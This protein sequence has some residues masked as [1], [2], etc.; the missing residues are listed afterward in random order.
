[1]QFDAP[2]VTAII[3]AAVVCADCIA[4]KVGLAVT[5]VDEV[6]IHIRKTVAVTSRVARCDSCL[7]TTVVHRLG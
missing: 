4:S 5:R 6:L 2:L 3:T 1:M 7:K